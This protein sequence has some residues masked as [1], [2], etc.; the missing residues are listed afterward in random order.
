ML[1]IETIV[2]GL[3]GSLNVGVAN[4][5]HT[6]TPMKGNYIINKT[7][8]SGNNKVFSYNYCVQCK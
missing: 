2:E 1:P 4:S 6:S 3:E 7:Q 5:V 8:A